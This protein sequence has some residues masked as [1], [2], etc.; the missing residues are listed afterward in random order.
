MIDPLQKLVLDAY[1][2]PRR[3][4]DGRL[5]QTADLVREQA[6]R[7]RMVGGL[8]HELLFAL[9]QINRSVAVRLQ[10]A[11]KL[12]EALALVLERIDL[13]GECQDRDR[14]NEIY[15][16]E[17][18]DASLQAAQI[19]R[20]AL[21]P[22][23]AFRHLERAISFIL[24]T[25]ISR[26]DPQLQFFALH[27]SDECRLLAHR[28]AQDGNRDES[29]RSWDWQLK[30]CALLDTEEAE[31]PDQVMIKACVL[32]DRGQ[33]ERAS[34]LIQALYSRKHS[35]KLEPILV[36]QAVGW[37]L[38]D[39]SP[40]WMRHWESVQNRSAPSPWEMQQEADV[41][42]TFLKEMCDA[43]ETPSP[44][45]R[46]AIA[47]ATGELAMRAPVQRNSGQLDEAER[48]VAFLISFGLRLVQ[49]FPEDLG[50]YLVLGEAYAQQAKNSWK[51]KDVGAIRR[52]LVQSI[53][54]LTRARPLDP[55]DHEVCT[56]L[57]DRERR[58][59]E[60][61]ESP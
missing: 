51:R 13:I 12:D 29:K 2:K 47:R 17:M 18:A 48:T 38:A 11:G 27:A 40:R 55:N 22:L 59:A 60:L 28:L 43:L 25:S 8:K 44:H 57:L 39:W 52:H 23:E 54:V 24:G 16:R 36:R 4:D 5:D 6:A 10:D 7:V 56:L 58:L 42:I 50:S 35:L 19:A 1:S 41:I 20:D 34:S 45:W 53:E 26:H 3:F 49:R 37:G 15:R 33:W 9:N 61:P 46:L 30:I 21:R 14:N 32:A 31:R